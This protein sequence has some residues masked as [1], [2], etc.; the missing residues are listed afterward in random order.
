MT[1][2]RWH[3]QNSETDR[4]AGWISALNTAEIP[5]SAL[6]TAALLVLDS[7]GVA[8]AARDEPA[9]Q[10]L[11]DVLSPTD[12][13]GQVPVIGYP[14]AFRAR[15]AALVNG[16]MTHVL[17]FDDTLLPSRLHAAGG[18]TA[19]LLA[20]G[21]ERNLQGADL[22]RGF[23]VGFEIAAAL[24]EEIHPEAYNV[25]WHNAGVVVPLGATAAICS[26]LRLSTDV[27]LRALG[28]AA[29]HSAGLLEN[30]G[31]MTKSLHVGTAAS[32]GVLASALA[33]RGFTGHP[34]VLD[35]GGGFLRL[36]SSMASD[37]SLASRVG[38]Y[39][40]TRT[41]FKP[42]A[43]GVVVHAAID[44]AIS[45]RATSGGVVDDPVRIEVI[46]A[47]HAMELMGASESHPG[48]EAE[49]SIPYVVAAA[50]T[51][52]HAGPSVFSQG[53]PGRGKIEDLVSK[54]I[55]ESD[56]ALDQNQARLRIIQQD[57]TITETEI[58]AAL[59]S[60]SNPMSE[61]DVLEKFRNLVIPVL[62]AARCDALCS[63]VL[64]ASAASVR[65]ITAAF[66]LQ[67]VA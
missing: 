20:V 12:G 10:I 26:M 50:L 67:E 62:G 7:L 28:I 66:V 32:V 1:A 36:F 41:G 18:I 16:T 49:F 30:R 42:Y 13:A 3:S 52:G 39:A 33:S 60:A 64:G 45:L 17:D 47:Q 19:A 53:T 57:G 31:T 44:A 11:I 27:T 4:I 59:G 21:H 23:V 43:C 51:E 14:V 38:E 6:Q 8:L 56:A 24:A 55:V 58:Q 65:D 34:H 46:V 15:D 2:H 29:S 40:I 54:V 35:D 5:V 48:L 9:V 37:R 61:A 25:G 63:I 22:L